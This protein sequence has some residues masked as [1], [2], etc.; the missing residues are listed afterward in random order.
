MLVFGKLAAIVAVLVAVAAAPL[1]TDPI[2]ITTEWDADD[3]SA[4]TNDVT[5]VINSVARKYPEARGVTVTSERAMPG[6]YAYTDG[7]TISFNDLYMSHPDVVQRLVDSDV[8]GGFHPPLGRCSGAE[9]IAYH[10]VAHVI[11][12]RRGK[13]AQSRAGLMFRLQ[14]GMDLSGYSYRNGDF[15]SPEALAEAFASAQCNG[16]NADERKLAA[17][18]GVDT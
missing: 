3:H 15:Y 5:R 2:L 9:F 10:E 6:V 17:L 16:G 14:G 8:A 1:S 12:V 4:I 13:V 18:L 11:D 7:E